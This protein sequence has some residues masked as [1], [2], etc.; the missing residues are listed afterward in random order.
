M[1][2]LQPYIVFHCRHFVRYIGI[3]NP[4]CVNLLQFMSSAIPR[5]LKKKSI[6]NRFPGILKRGTHTHTHARTH[7]HKHTHTHTRR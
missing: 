7:A 1:A 3:R 4:I 6:S 5:N 2:E